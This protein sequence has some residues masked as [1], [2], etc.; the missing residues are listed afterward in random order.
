MTDEPETIVVAAATRGRSRMF[1]QL[2]AS[3]GE[4]SPPEDAVLRFVFV[5]NDPEF[6]IGE[7]VEAFAART[8]RPAEAVHEPRLGIP[9]ARN[10]AVEA[11]LG[12]G[13]NWLAFIDDDETPEPDWIAR[14][15]EGARAGGYDLVGGPVD[16]RAPSGPLTRHQQAVFD[17]F[18]RMAREREAKRTE[19][20]QATLHLATN[21]WLCAA[22]VLRHHGLRFDEGMRLTGGSDTDFSIRAERAGFRL[23]WVP[24]AR[25]SE[26]IP[27]DKLSA[28]YCFRRARDQT[29]AK[30]HLKYRKAGAGARGKALFHF[31]T[32]GLGGAVR[33]ALWPVAGSYT[34][35]R[36]IRSVGVGV[37]WLRAALGGSSRL[38][39]RV[40]SD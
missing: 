39:D 2:L 18:T 24:D 13:A 38:Y 6:T 15:V 33:V 23:G 28:G 14:L 19:G 40:I 9:Q 7:D 37:G 16:Q 35:L 29:M 10:A 8:G 26:V 1:R 30:Y 36:G 27:A 31:L 17:Y 20:R 5:Q 34:G 11:A 3:L 22:H 32:K 25:V 12:A 21:N 4:L